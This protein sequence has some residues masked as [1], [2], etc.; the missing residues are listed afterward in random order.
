MMEKRNLYKLSEMVR[1]ELEQRPETRSSDRMLIHSVYRDYYG[2]VNDKWS[3]VI[4]NKDLPS[5]ESIRRCRQ[6]LQAKHEDL[7]A[8][9]KIEQLRFDN[10][11]EYIEY[12]ID[13]QIY[14]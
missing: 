11:K 14:I 2:I 4:L 3:N 8:V 6:K 9:E 12:A 1:S 10:Q 7:R 5:F 13:S